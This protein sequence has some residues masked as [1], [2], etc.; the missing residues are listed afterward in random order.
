MIP[1]VDLQ[2]QY[3][4]IKGELDAAVARVLAGGRYVLGPEV[5]AFEVEFAA[6]CGANFAVAVNSGTSALHLALLATG[7]G[8]GSEVITV[9]MTFVATVAA[10]LYTG[11]RPVF[12]DIDPVSYTMDPRQLAAAVT[13]RTKAVLPVHLYG[14]LAP[15]DEISMIARRQHLPVIED[16]AQAHGAKSGARKAGTFGAVGCFSFYPSK[17]LGACGEAGAI[18]TDDPAIARTVRMLRNWGLE[19]PHQHERVAYN[20]RLEEIQAAILRVKLRRLEEWTRARQEH[21]RLYD[22]LLASS[23]VTTPA[24]ANEGE[25]VYHIYGIRAARRDEILSLLHQDGIQAAVHYPLPV[26]LQSGYS[27]LGFREGDFPVSEMLAREELSLPLYPELTHD[28]IHTVARA[29]RTA[30]S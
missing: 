28:Q 6:F 26:H 4:S 17:N 20:Y 22:R 24:V 15:M 23:G 12:V 18:V 9:P 19:R 14:R 7:V 25:H 16:A 5:D 1:L 27:D 11:A 10:I 29:L 8:P 2:A 30:A 3:Q 13:P 21:A